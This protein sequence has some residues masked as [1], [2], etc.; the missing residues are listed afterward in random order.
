MPLEPAECFEETLAFRFCESL[1]V[2]ATMHWRRA[3]AKG[4][5][6]SSSSDRFAKSWKLSDSVTSA[7]RAL[8][9]G[10]GG[11]DNPVE[12]LSSESREKRFPLE[13][14]CNSCVSS[15]KAGWEQEIYLNCF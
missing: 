13:K 3:A 5:L 7:A 8:S 9:E 6:S 10:S 2:F 4:S 12:A 11:L 1:S 14:R 15:H